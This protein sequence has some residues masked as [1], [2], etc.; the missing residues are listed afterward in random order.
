MIWSTVNHCR[1]LLS[2]MNNLSHLSA[3]VV[4]FYD[5]IYSQSRSDSWTALFTI[6]AVVQKHTDLCS[7]SPGLL[8]LLSGS[9]IFQSYYLLQ[10]QCLYRSFDRVS[11]WWSSAR[12]AI[13]CDPAW[14]GNWLSSLFIQANNNTNSSTT[15]F[16]Q[17]TTEHT[18]KE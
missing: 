1:N 7:S 8:L 4:H 13:L 2:V 9:V 15:H 16:H 12:A 18:I 11:T 3:L 10:L 5:F 17:T 14:W 6:P